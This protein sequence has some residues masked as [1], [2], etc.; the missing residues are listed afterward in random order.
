MIN[1]FSYLRAC[2]KRAL[3]LYPA[4]VAFTLALM[5]GV[6]L[7]LVALFSGR[8]GNEENMRI[9]VGIV[10]DLENS[11]LD[12][13]FAALE[14]MDTS[15]F[16]IDFQEMDEKTAQKELANGSLK[17]YV[18]IPKGFVDS[19]ADGGDLKLKYYMGN[20][21]AVLSS[22]LMQEVIDVIGSV[23]TESQC[24]VYGYMDLL[25]K[26]GFT[27]KIQNKLA[28]E[29]TIEYVGKIL[30]REQWYEINDLGFSGG[31]SFEGYYAASFLIILFML[32]GTVCVNLLCKRDLSLERLML[33]KGR[34]IAPVMLAEYIPFLLIFVA[35]LLFIAT[36]AA[37]VFGGKELP[38]FLPEFSGIFSFLSFALALLPAAFLISS[39]QF[40]L[41][42]LTS[43]VVSA[44]LLQVLALIG[45]SYA[46]GLLYPVYS[47]PE[48]LQ[49]AAAILPTGVAFNYVSTVL[50]ASPATQTLLKTLIYAAAFLAVS[51]MVRKIKIRGSRI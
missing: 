44:V 47:L 6:S 45:L 7:I 39:M 13:G 12:I 48:T 30:T 38:A 31:L 24:A 26:A 3:K 37:F 23:V 42:E 43:S 36:G 5:L 15:R 11:Y 40:M 18:K 33:S 16:Y 4:I 10:G 34:G 1:F 19:V 14:S 35:N 21:P 20:S 27:R 29:L 9:K 32:W 22:L 49:K 8:E 46:S 41:Y 50:T 2:L 51:F 17:G 28:E 25:D